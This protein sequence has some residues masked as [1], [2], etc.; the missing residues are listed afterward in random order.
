MFGAAAVLAIP[1]TVFDQ[2]VE[3]E[4]IVIPS[5]LRELR[6]F[7]ANHNLH[8]ATGAFFYKDDVLVAHSD[9]CSVHLFHTRLPAFPEFDEVFGHPEYIQGLETWKVEAKVVEWFIDPSK[10]NDDTPLKMIAYSRDRTF[11]VLGNVY[12]S[13]YTFYMRHDGEPGTSTYL[14]IDS[15]FEGS[16]EAIITL[17]EG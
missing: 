4:P 11:T 3:T 16:G 9:D 17:K 14:Y 13:E 1:K 10:C 8:G 6:T 7:P 5:G 2:I 12:V 15:E